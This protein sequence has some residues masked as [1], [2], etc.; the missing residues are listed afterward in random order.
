MNFIEELTNDALQDN[1][2]KDIFYKAE[3]YSSQ[4]FFQVQKDEL[5]EKEYIDLLRFADILSHSEK[6]QAK[7]KSY[8]IISLLI[9]NYQSNEIFQT[10]ANS[11]MTRLGN[12]PAL[13]LFNET[14]NKEV[15][16]S[17][18]VLYERSLK[19]TFQK[20]PESKLIFTDAQ[21]EIFES[22]KNNNHFSFSGPTSLGKSFIIQAFIR[23]LITEHRGTDNIVILVPSRALINQ[24]VAKLK[25]EFKDEN[26]YTV[27]AHPSV[28]TMFR[29]EKSR[30]IFIFTPERLIAYMSNI[31][32]PKIDY[33]FVDEAHKIISQKDTRSPLYYHSILQAERKSIKLYFASP[34]IQNPEVFLHIF[35]KSTEENIAIRTSPVAQNR[36][37]LDLIDNNCLMLSDTGTEYKIPIDYSNNT[38][39]FWLNKLGGEDKSIIYCNSK[40]DT[41]NYALDF[42]KTR[43]VK[44][45]EALTEVIELVKEYLHEKYYLI[46][47]LN[48]GIAFHFG[49]LPQTIREKVEKLFED[50][51]LDYLFSTSTLLEGV[52][53]P[54]KNIFI[55]SD[56]IGLS[57]FT[58]VDFWN[59]AGR[60]GRLS[61][62]MSGNI[63]CMRVQE[64]K[65]VK[66]RDNPQVDL[67]IVKNKNTNDIE[68]LIIKGQENF[69]K[70]IAASL[71]NTNF[72]N[73][74]ASQNKKDIWNHYANLTLLHEMKGDKS[75]LRDN[76]IKK[77]KEAAE[78]LATQVKDINIPVKI[79]SASS[80]IKAK[81]Q[82]NIFNDQFLN[83]NILPEYFDYDVILKYLEIICDYY[84]WESE[85]SGGKNP[86]LPNKAI[87]KYYAVLMDNWMKA[88]PLKMIISS[89]IQYYKKK[90]EIW[91][92]NHFELF[93]HKSKK[94]IN[95]VVNEVIANIDNVLRFK[96]KNYFENYH[97][98][99]KERLGDNNAGANWA[100]YLEYGTTDFKVI[101]LQN[102]GIPR[103][104]AQY[105]LDNHKEC[106]EFDNNV[107]T[108]IKRDL[109]KNNFD[110]N[111]HEYKEYQDIFLT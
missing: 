32:N 84:N 93:D 53:L 76:F 106:L 10:F 42:A 77:N 17:Y 24:T 2:L 58:D 16:Q 30:Y 20:I 65:W 90:G 82:N 8:K 79:I 87:L 92:V 40:N 52:N 88:K 3:V 55:L 95:M 108:D 104:L 7:N 5:S 99:L 71:K 107:L 12:F 110:Q 83:K 101:E 31:E 109:L 4:Y 73:K 81:Y 63:I 27:L 100:D 67:D 54:A 57:K 1:Y 96:L 80:M 105:I 14:F 37:F 13:Q 6:S 29:T 103:H 49:N 75:V 33:L 98:I 47:C 11:I 59:L 91:D 61:K 44:E 48:K 51:V 22:L 50:K 69:Y 62:E 78:V 35:E 18:E 39:F 19:E 36:Y 21:Y 9:Q 26:N 102:I 60:A 89:S 64:N 97:N 86:M 56:M 94:H 38:F 23:H 15:I 45:D 41:I 28:P 68:P 72:T 111:S 43:K 34:N 70:N 66:G 46:D 74:K 25:N 85:E